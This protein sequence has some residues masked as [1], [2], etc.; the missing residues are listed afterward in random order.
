MIRPVVGLAVACVVIGLVPIGVVP[1]ALRVG[2]LVAGLPAGTADVIGTTAAGPA[3]VFTVGLA[4][5]LAV[6]WGLYVSLSRRGGRPIQAATWGCGYPTPTPRMAY[7]ASSFAAPL[8][9]VFR[10]F[11]GVRT[12]R[13]A[14]AFATHAVDPVLDGVLVPTWRGIRGG[15]AWLRHT[16]RGGLSRYLL[17][18]GAAV[19]ASLLYLLAG[20]RTP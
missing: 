19:V 12:H 8:L 17:W 6:T 10:S 2:S 5:G 20:A 16:Q 13:T 9:D 4:L 3:T 15:A 7:T 18:V 1:P 11:A 14:Q